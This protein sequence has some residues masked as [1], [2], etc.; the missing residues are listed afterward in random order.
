MNQRKNSQRLDKID[1]KILKAVQ[2]NGDYSVAQLAN[3]VGLSATPCWSRLQKLI[4]NKYIKQKVSL[5]NAEKI[6]MEVVVFVFITAK[7]ERHWQE[8]FEST[9]ME[10]SEITECFRMSGRNDYLLKVQVSSVKDYDNFYKRLVSKIPIK[11]VNSSIALEQLKY[12]TELSL[13]KLKEIHQIKT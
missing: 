9:V 2:K 6:G 3:S 10:F 11:K 7:H 8:E 5:L 12:T 13:D 1:Y 4:Q